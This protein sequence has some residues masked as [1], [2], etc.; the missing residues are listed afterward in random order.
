LICRYKGLKVGEEV[1]P[2]ADTPF[3]GIPVED[4]LVE[5]AF[6]DG[7]DCDMSGI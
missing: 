4:T 2:A 7:A 5:F 1:A 3:E 6:G